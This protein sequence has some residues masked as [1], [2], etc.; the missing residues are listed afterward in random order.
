MTF[1]RHTCFRSLPVR[2]RERV[3][4]PGQAIAC[5]IHR[6]NTPRVLDDIATTPG[7]D[8][9]RKQASSRH[10]VQNGC[11]APKARLASDP[12]AGR[13]ARGDTPTPPDPGAAG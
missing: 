2:G 13:L 1:K 11:E 12:A 10:R 4:A 5:D 6:L 8:E 7:L 3:R 9:P